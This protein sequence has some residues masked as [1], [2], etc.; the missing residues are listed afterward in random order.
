MRCKDYSVRQ[1]LIGLDR[2]GIVGLADAIEAAESSGLEDRAA[3]VELMLEALRPR[4]YIPDDQI[5]RYRPALWRELLRHRGQDFRALFSEIP[6]T[7]YGEPGLDRDRFV[8]A[9]VAALALF[10]LRPA[11][12]FA[13]P[14]EGE[15]NPQLVIRG[16]VV[17]RGAQSR[18]SMENAVRRT[19][20]DW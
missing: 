1:I 9:V 5:E 3:L 11:V 18:R 13:P 10:E 15:P 19:L 2:I 12:G 8:E 6:V 17:A 14:R 7:V 20:S 4:N 16:E